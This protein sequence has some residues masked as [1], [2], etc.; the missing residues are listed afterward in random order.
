M[1]GATPH[2]DPSQATPPPSDNAAYFRRRPL[3]ETPE[4]KAAALLD[5][6][7]TLIRQAYPEVEVVSESDN[8]VII[9]IVR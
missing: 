3:G 4:M 1:P 9:R 5:A 2:A 6:S 7:L 8:E